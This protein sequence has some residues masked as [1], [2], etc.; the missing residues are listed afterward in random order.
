VPALQQGGPAL[1]A[2]LQQHQLHAVGLVLVGLSG[3]GA[4]EGP[5]GVRWRSAA[6]DDV[7]DV[8]QVVQTLSSLPVLV[9]HSLGGYAVQMC[10]GCAGSP[11]RAGPCCMACSRCCEPYPGARSLTGHD[12]VSF[13]FLSQN[14]FLKAPAACAQTPYAVAGIAWDDAVTNRSG[15]RFGPARIARLKLWS[16]RSRLCGDNIEIASVQ[17]PD[18]QTTKTASAP[19][20]AKFS[21]LTF[22]RPPGR[23]PA[24]RMRRGRS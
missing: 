11:V 12:M 22:P 17:W 8:A 20:T 6:H 16:G 7:A 1:A 9:G 19:K 24:G 18:E 15:A 3:H 13:A 21:G 10:L 4:S 23:P 2:S 14:S 5:A